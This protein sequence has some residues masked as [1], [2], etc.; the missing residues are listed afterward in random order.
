MLSSSLAIVLSDLKCAIKRGERGKSGCLH[1]FHLRLKQVEIGSEAALDTL[2]EIARNHFVARRAMLLR[3]A[4][5]AVRNGGTYSARV[6]EID[7]DWPRLSGD[8]YG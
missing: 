5:R 1:A 4:E 8:N 7:R 6:T 2:P 3:M